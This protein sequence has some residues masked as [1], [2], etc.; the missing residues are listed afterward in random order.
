MGE[1]LSFSK[2]SL[3]TL[4]LAG[5]GF[6]GIGLSAMCE[7]GLNKNKM[8]QNL[9]LSDISIASSAEDINGIKALA[10]IIVSHPKLSHI[11]LSNNAMNA[12]CA[13][14]F[15]P[16]LNKNKRISSFIVDSSLP[17]KLYTTLSR[18]GTKSTKKKKKGKKKK[19]K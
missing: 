4:N 16:V 15:V 14:I 11:N 5:N 9:N 17:H 8:L 13:S 1:M 6:G 7:S 3:I 10:S 19:K 18:N 2:S 12:S